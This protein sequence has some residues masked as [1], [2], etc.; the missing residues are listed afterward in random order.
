MTNVLVGSEDEIRSFITKNTEENNSKSNKE[1]NL[2]VIKDATKQPENRDNDIKATDENEKNKKSSKDKSS[3]SSSRKKKSSS[4]KSKASKIKD[5]KSKDSKSKDSKSKDSKSKDSKNEKGGEKQRS[6]IES[7]KKKIN[8]DNESHRTRISE[9]RNNLKKKRKEFENQFEMM[10]QI[11]KTENN[12]HVIS[13]LKKEN[14][15]ME[16]DN[17]KTVAKLDIMRT[18]NSNLI[19]NLNSTSDSTITENKTFNGRIMQD[20]EKLEDQKEQLQYDKKA[21]I[22]EMKN[23][24]KKYTKAAKKRV[25]CQ[26]TMNDIEDLLMESGDRIKNSELREGVKKIIEDCYSKGEEMLCQVEKK[27]GSHIVKEQ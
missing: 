20:Y 26:R 23:Y 21:S 4:S 2:K 7:L 13:S 3:K 9:E 22:K 12:K 16:K 25:T 5:S 17:A 19:K 11:I 8:A 10:E 6:R 15:K 18:N 1:S 27:A 24:E 14:K